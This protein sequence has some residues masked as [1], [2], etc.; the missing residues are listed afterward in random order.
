MSTE[1]PVVAMPEQDQDM[2]EEE[3]QP[4]PMQEEQPAAA[5]HAVQV[6]DDGQAGGTPK[7]SAAALVGHHVQHLPISVTCKASMGCCCLC[8]C[9][10]CCCRWWP[11]GHQML[12]RNMHGAL[13]HVWHHVDEIP[14]F[15][16]G[17]CLH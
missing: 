12:S 14:T 5:V 8:N 1:A 16:F 4:E 3:P 17:L 10:S 15:S 13:L 2:M 11:R 7:P 9:S 6:K